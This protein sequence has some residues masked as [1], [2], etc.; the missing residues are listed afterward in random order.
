MAGDGLDR[1]GLPPLARGAP[2]CR[3]WV[4]SGVGSTPARAGSTGGSWRSRRTGAVYPRSRG[5]HTG[6]ELSALGGRGL[7][8]LARGAPLPP[9]AT[10]DLEWSTPARAGSTQRSESDRRASRV[11]PRSRGEHAQCGVSGLA[12]RGLPPLARGARRH[13]DRGAQPQRSTPARAGSTCQETRV[14]FGMGVYPRSRGEHA[15]NASAIIRLPGLPPLARGA[16]L[17]CPLSARLV[18][19]TPARAGST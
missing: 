11:Y 9:R 4:A 1:V 15:R 19:S 5:E 12:K 10:W 7:P 13:P 3:R 18:R 6:A 16:L 2:S 14:P 17:L 8:P